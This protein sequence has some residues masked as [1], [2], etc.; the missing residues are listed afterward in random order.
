MIEVTLVTGSA[1][2]LASWQRLTPPGVRLISE[3]LN[4]VEVQPESP[5]DTLAIVRDKVRR[6][7]A[8]LRRPVVVEDV[9][10]GLT[11]L[12]GFPG[13][14]IKAAEQSIGADALWVLAGKREG[15][16][17]VSCTAA[18]FDGVT[19]L[20]ATGAQAG[21]VVAPRT[22]TGWGFDRVFVPHGQE[23]T[24][25]QMTAAQKDSV[26]YRAAAIARLMGQVGEL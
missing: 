22:E 14:Y 16:A 17:Y 9:S 24:F 21:R 4:Q 8:A 18:Y 11:T 26:G 3:D 10:A 1:N 2:K 23:L 5:M 20:T 25:A 19:E 7:Y 12:N 13:P 6:A 15:E